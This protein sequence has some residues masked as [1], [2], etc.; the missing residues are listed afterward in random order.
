MQPAVF[1]AEGMTAELGAVREE[2]AAGAGQGN[3]DLGADG[4]GAVSDVDGLGFRYVGGGVAAQGSSVPRRSRGG[5]GGAA[6]RRAEH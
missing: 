2:D 5:T 4:L 1:D 6:R 3:V